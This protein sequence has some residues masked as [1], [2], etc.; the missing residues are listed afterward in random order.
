M[1]KIHTFKTSDHMVE[2][3]VKLLYQTLPSEGNLML[4]G[5]TTP[6]VAYNRIASSPCPVN[7]DRNIFLSDERMVHADSLN[8]NAGN[9]KPMLSALQCEDRFIRVDTN[10][11]AGE[12]AQRYA[13]SLEVLTPIDLGLLGMGSDGHTAGIFTNDQAEQTNSPL[14]ISTLRPDGMEGVSVAPALLQRIERIVLLVAGESKRSIVD[15]LLHN[16]S[17]IPTG[18]ALS[19]HPSIE[20]W[21]DLEL[22]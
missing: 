6:Y 3:I 9:L 17:T 2:S 15:T 19:G 14:V 5:G 13:C 1:I 21:T 11:P 16:P 18:L 12:A 20:L 4:S 22:G 7:P 8:S 10:V